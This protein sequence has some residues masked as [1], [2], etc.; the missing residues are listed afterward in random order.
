VEVPDGVVRINFVRLI[1]VLIDELVDGHV[2]LGVVSRVE[3][4]DASSWNPNRSQNCA[5]TQ[6]WTIFFARLFDTQF[7]LSLQ[8]TLAFLAYR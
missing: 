6:T 2:V 3:V 7:F 1:S 4:G 5:S 8:K